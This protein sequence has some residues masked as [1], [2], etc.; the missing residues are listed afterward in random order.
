MTDHLK[1]LLARVAAQRTS[2]PRP[3]PARAEAGLAAVER[4]IAGEIAHS[5]GKAGR[6]LAEAIAAASATRARV[7]S[8]PL[9]AGERAVLVERFEQERA[10]AERRLRDLMIQREALGWRN[11]AD[12]KRD[13]VIPPALPRD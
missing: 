4:E 5:L 10:L 2:A 6:L 13:Y 11:H 9:D 1:D 7:S 3:A 8:A 12:V